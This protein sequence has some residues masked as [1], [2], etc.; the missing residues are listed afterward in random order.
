MHFSL[1]QEAQQA[2][3]VCCWV[4]DSVVV[5]LNIHTAAAGVRFS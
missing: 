2:A 3:S 1:H 4:E 5:V